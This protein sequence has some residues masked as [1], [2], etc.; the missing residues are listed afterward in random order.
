MTAREAVIADAEEIARIYNEGIED[1]VATFETRVR[2]AADIGKWFEGR[3]RAVVV[4]DGGRIIAFAA[5]PGYRPRDCYAGIALIEEAGKAGFWKL[6]S[7]VFVEN[8]ASRALIGTQVFW[9]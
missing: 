5:T 1:R 2:S 7:R 4:E 3:Y 8:R 9:K 6:V